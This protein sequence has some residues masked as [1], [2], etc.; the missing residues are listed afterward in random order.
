MEMTYAVPADATF[1]Q[2]GVY[3]DGAAGDTYY[4]AN[5]V[6]AF[7]PSIGVN[8]YAKPAEV[9]TP[10]NGVVPITWNSA[11][12]RFPRTQ[13]NAPGYYDIKFDA[14]AETGGQIAP[15][16][17]NTEG[18]LEGLD[19]GVV[20]GATGAVRAIAFRNSP[21]APIVVGGVMAQTVADVKSFATMNVT[22]GPDGYA[23]VNTGAPG[24]TWSNVAVEFDRFFLQ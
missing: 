14:Y 7:A 17:V 9:L 8:N 1:I 13:D 10:I 18:Q 5:P 15:T 6:L 4:V 24:D 19:A 12:I 23:W 21:K 11:R 3:F 16:V 20:R 2:V 22:F